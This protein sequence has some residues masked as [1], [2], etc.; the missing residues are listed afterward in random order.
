V[1]P[2]DVLVLCRERD[3]RA[4]D[5]RFTD[6]FGHWQHSTIPAS[7]LTAESFE[8]GFG[9]DGSSIR[10]WQS[11]HES[12]LLM[13]PKADTAFVDPFAQ[14]PTLNLICEIQDPITRTDYPFDPRHLAKRAQDYIAGTG[15]A[16]AV[17]IGAECEFFVFDSVRFDQSPSHG[18]Y[19]LEGGEAAWQQHRTDRPNLAYQMRRKEGYFPCPPHDQGMD[20]RNDIMM[21]LIEAGLDVECHHHEV[22]VPGQGEIDFRYDTLMRTA[23]HVM[24]YKYVVRNLARRHGKVATFMPKPVLG[25][26]G[27]GMHTH[28]SFWKNGKSL[29]SGRN[30]AGLSELGM[31]AI[32]GILKHSAALM[33]LTNPSTNSYKRMVPGYEAPVHLAYSQRNRSAAIRIPMYSHQPESK[34]IEFRCPDGTCNPYL[35]FAAIAMAA[36]DGIQN[37]IPPGDPLDKDIY[38]LPPEQLKA[39]ARVPRSLEASLEALASDHD[40]LLRGDVFSEEILRKWIDSKMADEVEAHRMVPDPF[41]FAR[42]FDA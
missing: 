9:F 26:N 18:F 24:L 4:V 32:G 40:F 25:D 34:R 1:T 16:D 8:E 30:Y 23:D 11:I 13:V 29:M 10:G 28:L 3:V 41:E 14:L 36:I 38:D 35:A 42:Y 2:R 20:L 17:Y 33:A 12:D 22:A 5:L 7:R 31:F 39:T 15:L 6:L 19:Y 27:S 21:S 37:R